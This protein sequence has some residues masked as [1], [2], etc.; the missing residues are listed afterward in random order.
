[1][2]AIIGNKDNLFNFLLDNGANLNIKNN[3]DDDS[4]L[5]AARHKRYDLIDNMIAKG[6]STIA[7]NN[8]GDSMKDLTNPKCQK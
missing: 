7:I 2:Y 5:L 6:A 8:D 1:M 3:N 4:V